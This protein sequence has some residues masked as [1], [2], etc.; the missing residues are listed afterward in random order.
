MG[1]KILNVLKNHSKMYLQAGATQR[2][3]ISCSGRL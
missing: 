1:V 2:V 3:E